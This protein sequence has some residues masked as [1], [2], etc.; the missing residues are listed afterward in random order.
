MAKQIVDFDV[1]IRKVIGAELSMGIVNYKIRDDV[2]DMVKHSE[3]YYPITGVD[4][5]LLAVETAIKTKEDI[6]G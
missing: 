3:M 1:L 2:A 6:T 4:A 5:L